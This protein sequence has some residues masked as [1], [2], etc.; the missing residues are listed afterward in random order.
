MSSSITVTATAPNNNTNQSSI[1]SNIKIA[2]IGFLGIVIF[3]VHAGL[4]YYNM[5]AFNALL[6]LYIIVYA[7]I[8]LIVTG[9]N[10]G[11]YSKTS[12]NILVNFS[13]YTVILQIFILGFVLIKIF[14]RR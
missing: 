4:L 9:K 10:T 5:G 13:L 14:T 6:C 3:L 1:K 2:F 8:V 12:F 7:I 11:C